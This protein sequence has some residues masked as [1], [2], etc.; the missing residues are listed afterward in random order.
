M[1]KVQ[2]STTLIKRYVQDLV[3]Y[4]SVIATNADNLE[5]MAEIEN[6]FKEKGFNIVEPE[7]AEDFIAS[8]KGKQW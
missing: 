1:E 7:E 5:V 3:V 4:T 6:E 2:I 8:A